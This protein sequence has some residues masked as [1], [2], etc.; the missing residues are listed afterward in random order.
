MIGLSNT[1]KDVM[2]GAFADKW[3]E[4]ALFTGQEEIQD[5]IY[6]RQPVL[7]SF[8]VEDGS[9]RYVENVEKV[10]F[11]GF[12]NKHQVD[13]WGIFDQNGEI[14]ALYRVLEPIEVSP[15]MDCKFRPGELRIGLP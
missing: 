4:V 1:A 11:E 12:N 10:L 8:P 5:A 15:T 6:R 3:F 9:V 2:L 14:Y 13:H 7:F